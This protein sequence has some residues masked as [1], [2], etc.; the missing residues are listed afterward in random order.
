MEI[1][2]VCSELNS[3]TNILLVKT[4]FMLAFKVGGWDDIIKMELREGGWGSM[5]W[6][7]LAQD[8]DRCWDI[9]NAV[10]NLRVP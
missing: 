6:M 4:E 2:A 7:D 3:H 5:D 8:K 10:M 1:I 9:V